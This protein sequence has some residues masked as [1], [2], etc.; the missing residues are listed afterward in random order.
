MMAQS[1]IPSRNITK[2][3]A[4]W[5][6]MEQRDP[7]RGRANQANG[8]PSPARQDAGGRAPRSERESRPASGSGRAGVEPRDRQHDRPPRH[9][10]SLHQH[11]RAERGFEHG[12]D[13]DIGG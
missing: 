4:N 7:S 6:Y 2:T 3:L 11:P 8:G 13:E 9:G 12:G 5:K 1:P 10:V